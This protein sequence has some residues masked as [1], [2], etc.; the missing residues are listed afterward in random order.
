MGR[1]E[2]WKIS[3]PRPSI[4]H[5]T[6]HFTQSLFSLGPGTVPHLAHIISFN[7]SQL[8]E[9]CDFFPVLQERNMRLSEAQLLA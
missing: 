8:Y 9:V 3:L 5:Y 6:G 4:G 2:D 1:R 7:E